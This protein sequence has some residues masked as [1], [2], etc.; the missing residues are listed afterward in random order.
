MNRPDEIK[1]AARTVA[2]LVMD[3]EGRW[4]PDDLADALINLVALTI[5][6][7]GE[8]RPGHQAL[9]PA[10]AADDRPLFAPGAE[11]YYRKVLGL[12]PKQE[13]VEQ[14][15][16]QPCDEQACLMHG[17]AGSI[18]PCVKDGGPM[19]HIWVTAEE[20]DPDVLTEWLCNACRIP[21]CNG[22]CGDA[23]V[24]ATPDA[25]CPT[26]GDIIA[27]QCHG[28]RCVGCGNSVNVG[29]H[30]PGSGYGGCV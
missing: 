6:A 17:D 3:E 9:V 14:P 4:N 28:E 2:R 22:G 5:A 13:G 20:G 26:H 7:A 11:E 27:R 25:G 18:G 24:G 21:R 16:R 29:S 12:G 30:G 19:R 15:K 10:T 8:V 23:S 1:A